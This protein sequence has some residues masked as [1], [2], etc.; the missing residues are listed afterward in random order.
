MAHAS[1]YLLSIVWQVAEDLGA[2]GKRGGD[3]VPLEEQMLQTRQG[4]KILH[5]TSLQYTLFSTY[6]DYNR[7]EGQDKYLA[8]NVHNKAVTYNHYNSFSRQGRG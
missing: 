5:L 6:N 4:V 3:R 7:A 1:T 8:C 2:V